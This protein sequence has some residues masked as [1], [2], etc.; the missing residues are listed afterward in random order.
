MS[1]FVRPAV[2][3]AGMVLGLLLV[4]Q[5]PR[6]ASASAE[7]CWDDP[8][9]LVDGRIVDIRVGLPLRQ[10]LT[11][12]STTLTIVIPANVQGTVLVDDISAFPMSTSISAT[13]AAWSGKGA[14]PITVITDVQSATPYEFSVT[15]TPLADLSRLLQAPVAARGVT[16]TRLLTPVQLGR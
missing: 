9:I 16:G 4:G 3:V 10:L 1:R 15:V 8:V 11:T 6:T 7:W 13:G 2:L 12:R 14:L 5:A